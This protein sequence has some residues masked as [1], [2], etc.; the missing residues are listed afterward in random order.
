MWDT[1]Y[2]DEEKST[3]MVYQTRDDLVIRVTFG[4]HHRPDEVNFTFSPGKVT[5]QGEATFEKSVWQKTKKVRET[6]YYPVFSHTIPLNMTVNPEGAKVAFGED[7]WTLTI[8]KKGQGG[9]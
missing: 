3:Y 7:T 2:R 9:K 6:R 4:K 1:E 8:P 5:I